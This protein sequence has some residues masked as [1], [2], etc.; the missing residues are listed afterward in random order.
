MDLKDNH[1]KPWIWNKITTRHK[2]N[3]CKTRSYKNK[4]SIRKADQKSKKISGAH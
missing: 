3:Y 2:I 4:K 1:Y